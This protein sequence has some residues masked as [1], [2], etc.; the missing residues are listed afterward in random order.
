[1]IASFLGGVTLGT[2]LTGVT[3]AWALSAVLLLEGFF[4]AGPLF[5]QAPDG[6]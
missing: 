3:G 5:W 4:L 1:M 2:V 6:P